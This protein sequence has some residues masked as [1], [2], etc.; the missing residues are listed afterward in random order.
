V[1][2][3]Q[4]HG[5]NFSWSDMEVG[6]RWNQSW[7]KTD[8][9]L[10][11]ADVNEDFANY[12]FDPA[13][14]AVIAEYP[15]YQMLGGGINWGHNGFVWKGEMGFKKNRHFTLA[16]LTSGREQEVWDTAIGFDYEA[17]GAYSFSLELTNQHMLDW[18]SS[19]L[20]VRR[21]ETIL[22]GV[23][24]K[25]W[26]NQIL[27]TQYTAMLQLQDREAFHRWEFIYDLSDQWNLELQLDY[28]ITKE[29]MTLLS[30]LE[31]KN[32]IALEVTFDF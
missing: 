24:R 10:M 30:Q 19:L 28:F 18:D 32:R 13:A 23:W 25:T 3:P 7:G 27:T 8:V 2:I 1:A 5:P 15:R 6:L 21:D 26:L 17:N 12:S 14:V 9:S 11:A 22:Y 31:D 4:S 29:T 20:L 16:D